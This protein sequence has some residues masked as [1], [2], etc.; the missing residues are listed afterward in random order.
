[1][2]DPSYH[3]LGPDQIPIAYP[4][5]TD[6]P[7]KIKIISGTT[8][9]VTSPVNH[10]GGCWYF[11]YIFNK[12][13]TFFQELREHFRVHYSYSVSSNKTFEILAKGW[14]AFIY[15]LKG[16]ASIASETKSHDSYHTLVLSAK[17]NE[18]GVSVTA[19]QDD[20]ELVLVRILFYLTMLKR[21]LTIFLF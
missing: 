19:T 11:H 8:L 2:Q 21:N 7:L 3:E 1:M 14:T 10:P 12:K 20:T 4:E 5:G 16:S 15:I 17:G 18:T 13:S 6:G 9:G